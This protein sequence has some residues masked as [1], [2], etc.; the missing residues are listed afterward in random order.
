MKTGDY[1]GIKAYV[2]DQN[3]FAVVADWLVMTNK[4][5][6]GKQ[7]IDRVLGSANKSLATDAQ[8]AK[9]HGAVKASTTAWGYVNTAALRDTGVAKKKLFDRQADN[10][11]VELILRRDPQ[12]LAADAGTFAFALDVSNKQVHLSVTAPHDRNWAGES[13]SCCLARGL[14]SCS[15]PFVG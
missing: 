4:D 13:P 5:E 15:L 8:F 6:L 2:V 12:H 1:R 11:L 9:A 7:I 10:P 14:G 3:K